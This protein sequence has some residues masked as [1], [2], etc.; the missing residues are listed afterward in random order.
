MNEYVLFAVNNLKHRGLRSW[1]TMIGIFIGIAAVVALIGM[2]EG[3]R[4]AI[5]AQFSFLGSDIL[6]VSASGGF[7]PPGTGVIKPLTDK[8]LNAIKKIPGVE[9]AA[10]RLIEPA[11]MVFNNKAVFTMAVNMPDG[12]DRKVVEDAVQVKAKSGRLLKDGDSGKVVLGINF[13]DKDAFGKEVVPGAKVKVQDKEFTVIG[14]MEKKGNFQ[15]DQA[16]LMNDADFRELFELSNDE[17]DIIAVRFNEHADLKALQATIERRLRSIRDVKQGEEDFQVTTPASIIEAINTTLIAVQI[18]IVVIASISL[19]VGGIGIMNTMYTSVVERTKEI[20]IMKS[21]G[22]RNRTIF[23][24]FFIESGLLG[25]VGGV[26]G[27][28]LGYGIATGLAF[29]GKLVLVSDLIAAHISL[30]LVIGA[31]VFSFVLGSVFGTLPAVQASR[32]SPVEALRHV[33]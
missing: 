16:V 24:L 26:M 12:E 14:I 5:N 19:L 18:F 3:L 15:I 30:M 2:G 8:E 27:I 21:I 13:A 23:T 4:Q 11:K 6:S 9:G 31:L 29:I 20:G 28:L 32:L 25:T 1:L 17:H 10:G 22:A 7:G 33:K